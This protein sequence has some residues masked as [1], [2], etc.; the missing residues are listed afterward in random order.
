M[1]SASAN[2]PSNTVFFILLKEQTVEKKIK[3]MLFTK[4]QKIEQVTALPG[5]LWYSC[6]AELSQFDVNQLLTVQSAEQPDCFLLTSSLQFLV[7]LSEVKF[8][9]LFAIVT[10]RERAAVFLNDQGSRLNF[11]CSLHSQVMVGKDGSVMVD[12][13]D[14]D[15][16]R[17]LRGV[18]KY[19][20][21]IPNLDGY[22]FAVELPVVMVVLYAIIRSLGYD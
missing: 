22:W 12:I 11:A 17:T 2:H 4:M 9:M 16:Q 10:C 18:V 14:Q 6:E 13:L 5:S 3:S 7:K 21:N 1:S 15:D 19:V 8:N 20:G